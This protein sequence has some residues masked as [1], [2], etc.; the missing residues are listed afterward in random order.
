MSMGSVTC[1]FKAYPWLPIALRIKSELPAVI[2]QVLH[3]LTSAYI[4]K[5]IPRPLH[6]S[7]HIGHA[8]P[9]TSTRSCSGTFAWAASSAKNTL[10][11]LFKWLNTFPSFR[12]QLRCHLPREIPLT[13]HEE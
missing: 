3:A 6:S 9:H 8:V 5:L 13:T 1:E 12:P 7:S 10:C 2:R 4:F 11:R